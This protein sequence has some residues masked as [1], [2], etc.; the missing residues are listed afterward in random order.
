MYIRKNSRRRLFIPLSGYWT[1]ITN[2]YDSLGTYTCLWSSTIHNTYNNLA[3][4]VGII[5]NGHIS[6]MRGNRAG[7][8]TVRCLFKK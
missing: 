6:V 1:E 5:K 7:A 2:K 4:G 3:Y 8:C